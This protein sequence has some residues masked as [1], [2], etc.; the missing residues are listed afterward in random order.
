M[1]AMRLHKIMYCYANNYLSHDGNILTNSNGS[2][3][4]DRHDIKSC[5]DLKDINRE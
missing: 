3:F 4:N 5:H 2:R 1:F